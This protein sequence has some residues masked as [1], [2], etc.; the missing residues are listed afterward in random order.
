MDTADT[1]AMLSKREQRD[2]E[3]DRRIEALRRK[4]QA[5]I[6]RYQEVE[7]DKKKA[8]AEGEGKGE[9]AEAVRSSM[10]QTEDLTITVNKVSRQEK[11]TVVT[12]SG[13][14]NLGARGD[15]PKLG[16]GRG[17][18]RQLLVTTTGNSNKEPGPASP[19]PADLILISSE[20]HQEYLRWKKEREAIDRERVARHMNSQGQW[21]R[22]WDVDKTEYM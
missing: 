18:R 17:S 19:P 1:G 4:N 16:S 7:D 15:G 8:A 2:E 14:S 10:G 5:L 6:K 22:A 20:E 13:S 21:R 3:L 12:K 9:E 11:R